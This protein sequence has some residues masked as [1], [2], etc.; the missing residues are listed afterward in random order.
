[1]SMDQEAPSVVPA[2]APPLQETMAEEMG[3]EDPTYPWVDAVS[4]AEE[5]DRMEEIQISRQTWA[6]RRSGEED[7]Q[8][9]Q[10]ILPHRFYTSI[11]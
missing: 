9:A 7:A 10:K 5:E 3:H 6:G 4:P 2:A 1:M 11:H 8:S